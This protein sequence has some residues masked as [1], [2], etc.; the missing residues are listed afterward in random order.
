MAIECNRLIEKPNRRPLPKSGH[1]LKENVCSLIFLLFS[2]L[3]VCL[4]IYVS[5][6][7]ACLYVRLVYSP[8][9][10]GQKRPRGRRL[11]HEDR[12]LWSRSRYLQK[13]LVCE[14]DKWNIANQVDGFGIVVSAG[15][16]REEWCVSTSNRRKVL[17]GDVFILRRLI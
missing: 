14:D 10:G 5:S 6:L 15:V 13:W 2:F 3:F 11:R 9:F 1:P 8:R 17:K 4:F 7:F 12:W 16:L